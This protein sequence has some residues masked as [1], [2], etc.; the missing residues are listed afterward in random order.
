MIS[1]LV[2]ENVGHDEK[3]DSFVIWNS[4]IRNITNAPVVLNSTVRKQFQ[5]LELTAKKFSPVKYD[6][7]KKTFSK[8]PDALSKIKKTEKTIKSLL[9][10]NDNNK[11]SSKKMKFDRSGIFSIHYDSGEERISNDLDTVGKS[12]FHFKSILLHLAESFLFCYFF[13]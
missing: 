10:K 6:F 3:M 13:V 1:D 4:A 9:S 7:L 12:N 8:D 11:Y 2:T 5:Y